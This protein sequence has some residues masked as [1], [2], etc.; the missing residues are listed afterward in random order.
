[1]NIYYGE[2]A[3]V[4]LAI[5][6][7]LIKEKNSRRLEHAEKFLCMLEEF[8]LELHRQLQIPISTP[9]ELEVRLG[10]DLQLNENCS[11]LLQD[12]KKWANKELKTSF[13]CL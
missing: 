6:Q 1:M 2:L 10:S 8:Y 11:R 13:R 12:M 3:A 9:E 4:V 5:N 7:K